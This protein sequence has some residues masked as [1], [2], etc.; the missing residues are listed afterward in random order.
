MPSF[1]SVA[2]SGNW[3]LVQFT[4]LQ[5]VLSWAIW[6]GGRGRTRTVAWYQVSSEDLKPPVEPQ[7]FLREKLRERSLL[8]AVGLLT[9]ADLDAYTEAEKSFGEL[10]VRSIATVGL[11]NA[12]RAGDPARALSPVGT[13]N[14]L[15]HISE[16]LSEEARVEALAVAVEA[17][18]AAL[19][20]AQIPSLET[21]LPATGTGT[22]CVVVA[23]PLEVSARETSSRVHRYAGK[24]TEVG[25]LIGAAVLE[26]VQRGIGLWKARPSR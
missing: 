21:G 9:S 22:D 17:R 3:L 5:E 15:V 19:L 23:S 13:I 4:S 11:R 16:P 1:C 25:S 7:E 2:R 14:L 8:G 24:H 12:L 10:S 6:G 18:T 26:A 20:K